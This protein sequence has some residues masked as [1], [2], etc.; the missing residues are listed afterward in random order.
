MFTPGPRTPPHEDVAKRSA[1]AAR[2]SG[3]LKNCVYIY[4]YIYMYTYIYMYIN[5]HT[6]MYVYIYIYAYVYMCV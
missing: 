5:I 1:A 3:S 2:Y 4:I 6:Y